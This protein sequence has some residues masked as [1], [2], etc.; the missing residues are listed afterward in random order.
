M[1]DNKLNEAIDMIENAGGFVMFPETDKDERNIRNQTFIEENRIMDDI[2]KEEEK[3]KND[4]EERK[5]DAFEE[6]D[7]ALKQKKFSYR[8]VEDICYEN[9]IDMDDIEDYINSYY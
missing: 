8:V 3:Y 5:N 1:A 9:G 7:E 4:Y 6:F 2:D